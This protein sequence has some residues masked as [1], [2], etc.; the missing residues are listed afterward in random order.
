M[1]DAPASATQLIM[2]RQRRRAVLSHVEDQI[3]RA[4]EDFPTYCAREFF[5]A[6]HV[7]RLLRLRE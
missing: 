1:H 6:G 3:G 2:M 4:L 5:G 7:A